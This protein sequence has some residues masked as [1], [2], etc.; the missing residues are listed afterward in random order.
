MSSLGTAYLCVLHGGSFE[1]VPHLLYT[2]SGQFDVYMDFDYMSVVDIKERV[3][4]LGYFNR[5]NAPFK[6]NLLPIN[7]D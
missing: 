6:D 3:V 7:N 2:K 4:N 5:H 1:I